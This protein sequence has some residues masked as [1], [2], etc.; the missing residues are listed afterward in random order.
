MPLVS[1][2]AYQA[3]LTSMDAER[4]QYRDMKIVQ[5]FAVQGKPE[6]DVIQGMLESIGIQSMTRGHSVLSVHPF[7]MDG[8]GEVRILV[9]E[10][11]EEAAKQAIKDF[12][13]EDP[14]DGEDSLE[15]EDPSDR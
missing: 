12:L 14:A 10:P 5:V 6:A 1:E 9:A 8:M 2:A 11:D 7:T 4:E 13:K 3:Q 15:S